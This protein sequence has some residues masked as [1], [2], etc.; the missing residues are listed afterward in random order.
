ME[1]RISLSWGI[2]LKFWLECYEFG[3]FQVT[4]L[5]RAT[6]KNWLRQQK[7]PLY[8]LKKFHCF[9]EFSYPARVT[10]IFNPTEKMFSARTLTRLEI[11]QGSQLTERFVDRAHNVIIWVAQQ[12][13]EIDKVVYARSSSY[14]MI[15]DSQS[16]PDCLSLSYSKE[17]FIYHSNMSISSGCHELCHCY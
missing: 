16:G 3:V 2:H 5:L 15:P 11:G 10:V 8:S 1:E 6:T 14:S 13:Y 12:S 4:F 9:R 7:T 17:D